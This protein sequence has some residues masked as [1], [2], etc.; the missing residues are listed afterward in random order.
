M[1]DVIIIGGGASGCACAINLKKNNKNINVI[2]LEQNDKILKKLLK[3]G[4]GKCNLGN[5]EFDM[6]KYY[7]S[8]KD[9][10][11]QMFG[12]FSVWDMLHSKK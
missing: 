8:N 6:S 9:K 4:N 7:C 5:L 11:Q 3:T 12:V 10:L 1:Y 2:I